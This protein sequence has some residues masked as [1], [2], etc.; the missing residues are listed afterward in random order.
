MNARHHSL[1]LE[2]MVLASMSV[3]GCAFGTRRVDLRPVVVDSGGDYHHG[4]IY[5]GQPQD[6]RVERTSVGCVRNGWG[7]R[8]AEV[9]STNNVA[10]WAQDSV[11]GSLRACGYTVHT[12]GDHTEM[13]ASA[14]TIVLGVDKVFCE[15]YWKYRAEVS[16]VAEVRRGADLTE[17]FSTKGQASATNWAST[18]GGYQDSLQAAMRDC[19]DKLMPKLITSIDGAPPPHQ[20]HELQE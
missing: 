19:L 15:T 10:S 2:V 7:M 12:D 17:R 4:E 1:L 20:E 11:A 3:A 14:V 5:L 9:E 8:T 6:Y 18:S 13:P 16:L